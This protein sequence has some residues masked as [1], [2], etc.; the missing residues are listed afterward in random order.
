MEENIQQIETRL[1]ALETWLKQTS[2]IDKVQSDT[3]ELLVQKYTNDI[4]EINKT[5]EDIKETMRI[6][7]NVLQN[8]IALIEGLTT[9]VEALHVRLTNLESNLK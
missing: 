2:E 7:Q 8:C 1:K 3:I 6:S 4:P 9:N 5:F